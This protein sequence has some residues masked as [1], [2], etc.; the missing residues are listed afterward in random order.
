M[1]FQALPSLNLLTAEEIENVRRNGEALLSLHEKIAARII[2]A[3]E[4]TSWGERDIVGRAERDGMVRA[5]VGKVAVVFSNFVRR[6]FIT[7]ITKLII[8]R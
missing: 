6:F 2:Q 3:E 7:A 8:P 1:Y 4:E 5:I